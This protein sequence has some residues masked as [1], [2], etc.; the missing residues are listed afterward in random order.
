MNLAGQL[1]IIA[2]RSRCD[3]IAATGKVKPRA[4]AGSL[5]TSAYDLNSLAQAGSLRHIARCDKRATCRPRV[6]QSFLDLGAR[7]TQI[8]QDTASF[9]RLHFSGGLFSS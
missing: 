9:D 1:F 5:R 7:K 2:G 4:Q 3:Y 6:D 8:W